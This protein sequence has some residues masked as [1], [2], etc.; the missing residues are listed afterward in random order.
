MYLIVLI[1]F[2]LLTS[3]VGILSL[4]YEDPD[5]VASNFSAYFELGE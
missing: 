5:R 1:P 3:F 2:L 4:M